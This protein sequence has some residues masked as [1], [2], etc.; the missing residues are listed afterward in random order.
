M[1]YVVRRVLLLQKY[2]LSG[3]LYAVCFMVIL[4]F[5]EK[6]ALKQEMKM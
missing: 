2:F 1:F 3:Q 6:S 5:L 4:R